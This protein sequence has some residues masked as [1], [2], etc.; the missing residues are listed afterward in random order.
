MVT[1]RRTRLLRTA[2]LRLFQ[3]AIADL[4]RTGDPWIAHGTAVLVPTRAAAEQLRRTLEELTLVGEHAAA[5]FALP[6]VLTRDEWYRAMADRAFP[7]TSLLSDVER[8]V[9]MLAAARA[10]IWNVTFAVYQAMEDP[11]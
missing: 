3:A 4:T 2:N 6:E 11:Q 9:C 7:S 5:V 10:G 8:Y 1:P